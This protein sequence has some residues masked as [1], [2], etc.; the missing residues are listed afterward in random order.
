MYTGYPEKKDYNGTENETVYVG[1]RA[2][3]DPDKKSPFGEPAFLEGLGAFVLTS[4]KG[5][6]RRK[7]RF[8][9]TLPTACLFAVKVR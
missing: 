8:W 2:G 7:G 9:C 3:S 4:V 1:W 6:E 5:E